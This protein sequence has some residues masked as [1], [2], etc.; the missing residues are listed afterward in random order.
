MLSYLPV[1]IVMIIA[2]GFVVGTIIASHFLGPRRHSVV[3]DAPF[4]CGIESQD[5]ARVRFSIKY[6]LVAILFVLFDVEIVFFYPWALSFRELGWLGIAEIASF[7]GAVS[8]AL[9]Y[10]NHHRVFEF[11]TH[12]GTQL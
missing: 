1:F 7:L 8:I 3:K 10:L 11:E 2:L 4:E 6:F 12:R 9:V 5:N